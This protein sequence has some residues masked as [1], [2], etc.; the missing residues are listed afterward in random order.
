[1]ALNLPTRALYEL[2]DRFRSVRDQ[3]GI[4]QEKLAQKTKLDR[5]YIGRVERGEQNITFKN[6]CKIA[7]YFGKDVGYFTK[8][9]PN[10]PRKGVRYSLSIWKRERAKENLANWKKRHFSPRPD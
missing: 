2:G 6:L 4:S 8:D 5:S 7:S 1:M 3:K 9:L 10:P